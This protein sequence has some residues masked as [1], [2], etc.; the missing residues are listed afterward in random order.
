MYAETILTGSSVTIES[1]YKTLLV[2]HLGVSAASGNA[3]FTGMTAIGVWSSCRITAAGNVAAGGVSLIGKSWVT[4]NAL[5]IAAG[6]GITLDSVDAQINGSLVLR[7][8]G[9]IMVAGWLEANGYLE[10]VEIFAGGDFNAPHTGITL[11]TS[12]LSATVTI[13]VGGTL[14]LGCGVSLDAGNNAVVGMTVEANR[15]TLLSLNLS[16]NVCATVRAADDLKLGAT[17]IEDDCAVT[18]LSEAGSVLLTDQAGL[19]LSDSTAVLPVSGY[20]A[21]GG[22]RGLTITAYKDVLVKDAVTVY[23]SATLTLT[24]LYGDIQLGQRTGANRSNGRL[25]VDRRSIVTLAALR[26][27]VFLGG[28]IVVNNADP[29]ALIPE[30]ANAITVQA[31]DVEAGDR[32]V[33]LSDNTLAPYSIR[34]YASHDVVLPGYVDDLSAGNNAMRICKINQNGLDIELNAGND[35]TLPSLFYEGGNRMRFVAHAGG[36]VR[37]SGVV[38]LRGASESVG[39]TYSVSGNT[40]EDAYIVSPVVNAKLYAVS[41]ITAFDLSGRITA[42]SERGDIRVNGNVDATDI[43]L[44]AGRDVTLGGYGNRM[45]KLT[46]TAGGNVLIDNPFEMPGT[47]AIVIDADGDVGSAVKPIFISRYTQGAAFF[48]QTANN[49]F[50]TVGAV[51]KSDGSD[52]AFLMTAGNVAGSWTLHYARGGVD[53]TQQ[54]GD[55]RLA[56]VCAAM[57][58]SASNDAVVRLMAQNGG[59][60][61]ATQDAANIETARNVVLTA[62]NGSIGMPSVPLIIR[63]NARSTGSVCACAGGSVSIVATDNLNIDRIASDGD[64]ALTSGGL[65]RAARDCAAHTEPHIAARSIRLT[66]YGGDVATSARELCVRLSGGSLLVTI[67]QGSGAYIHGATASLSRTPESAVQTVISDAQTLYEAIGGSANA[68]FDA[69]TNTITLKNSVTL[70]SALRLRFGANVSVTLDLCTFTIAADDPANSAFLLQSGTLYLKNGRLEKPATQAAYAAPL[71]GVFSGTLQLCNIDI[72]LPKARILTMSSVLL[73]AGARVELV[74]DAPGASSSVTIAGRVINPA[75][76]VFFADAGYTITEAAMG[77]QWRGAGTDAVALTGY[78]GT[79]LTASY[80]FIVTAL[81][82]LPDGTG[83]PFIYRAGTPWNPAPAFVNAV[84]EAVHV[85]AAHYAQQWHRKLNDYEYEQLEGAPVDAGVY[86]CTVTLTDEGGK[87]YRLVTGADAYYIVIDPKTITATLSAENVTG[88]YGESYS[89]KV[90]FS[91]DLRVEYSLDNSNWSEENPTVLALGTTTV[92]Y[93][94]RSIDSNYT[95]DGASYSK[96]V[97]I[98]YR[99]LAAIVQPS[100]SSAVYDGE[101]KPFHVEFTDADGREID[102]LKA[103]THYT[104]E[105]FSDENLTTL[106]TALEPDSYYVRGVLT[107]QGRVAINALGYDMGDTTFNTL[108]YQIVADPITPWGLY[109]YKDYDGET[110]VITPEDVDAKSYDTLV[111]SDAYD[112]K[113]ADFT[114]WQPFMGFAFTNV[115]DSKVVYVAHQ[116]AGSETYVAT[117]DVTINALPLTGIAAKDYDAEYD[118]QQHTVA[119]TGTLP[120]DTIEY[121]VD[122]GAWTAGTPV[123]EDATDAAGM[124]Y[125]RVTRAN[126][127]PTVVSALVSIAP[128]TLTLQTTPAI[129]SNTPIY[130]DSEFSNLSA[131]PVY[132]YF[133]KEYDGTYQ[134]DMPVTYAFDES[135]ILLRDRSLVLPLLTEYCANHNSMRSGSLNLSPAGNQLAIFSYFDPNER[136]GNLENYRLK[137]VLPVENAQFVC[138]I[139][140]AKTSQGTL[141]ITGGGKTYDGMPAA[142]VASVNG[143]KQHEEYGEGGVYVGLADDVFAYAYAYAQN[144]NGVWTALP[145]APKDVGSYRVT[146]TASHPYYQDKTKSIEFAIEKRVLTGFALAAT[147]KSEDG[148][149]DATVIVS[150]L[151]GNIVSGDDVTI[152]IANARFAAADAGTNLAVTYGWSLYGDH[153]NNYSLPAVQPA[154]AASIIAGTATPLTDGM[155]EAITGSFTFSGAAQTP[156]VTPI[157]GLV[158]NRDYVVTYADNLHA[159]TASVT[160]RGVGAYTGSVTR[161]FSIA[162]KELTEAMYS[163]VVGEYTYHAQVQT[164]V[165]QMTDAGV[166]LTANVHYK[167]TSTGLDAGDATLTITGLGDYAGTLSD[168]TYTIGQ[169]ILRPSDFTLPAGYAYQ[170]ENWGYTF[171]EDSS[172]AAGY[173]VYGGDTVEIEAFGHLGFGADGSEALFF[174]SYLVDNPNYRVEDRYVVM[175]TGEIMPATITID[176]VAA[177]DKY[178]DNTLSATVNVS[179]SGKRGYFDDVGV[180]VSAAAF[181]TAVPGTGK[182]VSYTLTLTGETARWYRFSNGASFMQGTAQAS[183]LSGGKIA[184]SADMIALNL[185]AGGYTYDGAEKKPDVVS[186]GLWNLAE[187]TDYTRIDLN[188]T[189]AGTGTV[190]ITGKGGYAGELRLPFTIQKKSL[191]EV[192]FSDIPAQMYV[193]DGAVPTVT[194]RPAL[195]QDVDYYLRYANNGAAGTAVVSVIGIGNYAGTQVKTFTIVPLDASGAAV[196]IDPASYT[197]TALMPAPEVVLNGVTLKNGVDY[198][199]AYENNI[200]PG[201]AQAV[202]TFLGNYSGAVRKAFVINEQSVSILTVQIAAAYHT[203]EAVEPAVTVKN[204]A[205]TLQRDVHYRLEFDHNIELGTATVRII[206][207]GGYT[208]ERVEPFNITARPQAYDPADP[209]EPVPPQEQSRWE[210]MVAE[211]LAAWAGQLPDPTNPDLPIDEGG[212]GRAPDMSDA[213][214]TELLAAVTAELEAIMGFL[215]DRISDTVPVSEST[216]RRMEQVYAAAMDRLE[217]G[218]MHLLHAD[219]GTRLSVERDS[220]SAGVLGGQLVVENMSESDMQYQT[221]LGMLRDGDTIISMTS[222]GIAGANIAPTGLVTLTF[223]LLAYQ[224]FTLWYLNE[225]G[226]WVPLPITTD[227]SGAFT[228]TLPCL[229]CLAFVAAGSGTRA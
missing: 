220:V 154:L 17:R 78:A 223:C 83:S 31:K 205:L 36:C 47:S 113:D 76:D 180:T 40:I 167:V 125:I 201:N 213:M 14:L 88:Y 156:T 158:P 179:Y 212:L 221:L 190:V 93:R 228:V 137:R 52:A 141:N 73:T 57:D 133:T 227:E 124:V 3:V 119:L 173:G 117:V 6:G 82:V 101:E 186:V 12:L 128:I 211:E 5:H 109:V 132:M 188:N 60:R 160:I 77:A 148:T 197:G 69:A 171:T 192:A 193:P 120:G 7:A 159:G 71:L 152:A 149:H 70:S 172:Y 37:F 206:G 110:T 64:V 30:G 68:S 84:M 112:P 165:V 95:T 29:S 90:S 184:L 96:T 209:I 215:D 196:S 115:A 157:G 62:V 26:G 169:A 18:L 94:A 135:A 224:T 139:E 170:G 4:T 35:I 23:N 177:V 98:V 81:S 56:L 175:G 214:Y 25:T 143:A 114:G 102:G 118:G 48:V 11:R 51:A 226:A 27:K 66:S 86:R 216:L 34:V 131:T 123:F 153:A 80:N 217:P 138:Y 229:T 116:R 134:I 49:L 59:I 9:N 43:S 89:I 8:G 79:K 45:G 99:T 65:I 2:D 129:W 145:G 130:V 127:A 58:C 222:I 53:V 10:N 140:V 166:L 219:T 106:T 168:K 50:V 100:D 161:T 91:G 146:V 111:W 55:M 208:G 189:G 207:L 174:T 16:G 136:L 75:S 61:S 42:V 85:D 74:A 105:V 108:P 185:P 103:G 13:R 182:T 41:D 150:T 107:D 218:R 198:T 54:T 72:A 24:A 163:G 225:A 210:G 20:I 194:S 122:N 191:N 32:L 142:P 176:S 97:T 39:A 1:A 187:G 63:Q 195:V 203:G 204:G 202:I 46:I 162:R 181:D 183:I 33:W 164:P 199:V 28:G 87:R 151:P 104:I 126:Y 19:G 22:S 21:H 67:P 44:I 121:R 178:F 144:D 15:I 92:F 200:D 155:F 38:D 147:D